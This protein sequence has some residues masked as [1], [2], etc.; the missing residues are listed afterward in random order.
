M[1]ITLVTFLWA[2]ICQAQEK[3]KVTLED[4]KLWHTIKTGATSDDGVWTSYSKTYMN[5]IDTLYLKNTKS[6]FEYVFPMGYNEKITKKGDRFAFLISGS[7][8]VLNTQSGKQQEYPNVIG[9]ELSENGKYLI[10]QSANTLTFEFV[11]SGKTK[12]LEHVKEYSVSPNQE[13]VAV[14]QNNEGGTAIKLVSLSDLTVREVSLESFELEYQQAVWNATGNTLGYYIFDKENKAYTIGCLKVDNLIREYKLDPIAI[15]DFPP[16]M[17]IIK[18]QLYV[19][20]KGDKVFF[21]TQQKDLASHENVKVWKSTDKELPPKSKINYKVW[22]VWLPLEDKVYEIEQDQ[23]KVCAITDNQEKAVLLDNE[24]YLPL[25]EYGDRYSDVYLMDLNTGQKEKIIEKQ[26]R[27]SWHLVTEP[28]GKYIAYFKDHHWWSYDIKNKTHLCI[29]KSIVTPFYKLN[30]DRLDTHRAF[31]FGG[32]T[33]TGELLVY[34]EY[35]VWMIAANGKKKERLTSGRSR[36]VTYRVHKYL[37][38]SIRDGFYGY[39]E[40]VYDLK[41]GLLIHTLNN[42]KLSEGFGVWNLKTG[43]TEITHNDF[44]IQYIKRISGNSFLYLSK[45]FDEPLQI[46]NVK[47]DGKQNIIVKSNEHQKQFYWGKSELIYYQS[48]EGKRLKGALFYPANYNDEVNYP[49]IVSIYENKSNALHD[50]VAPSLTSYTGINLTNFTQEGYFVLYPDIAYELN[51]PGK[52]ALDCVNAAIDKALEIGSIDENKLGLMGHSF[53]GFEASYIVSQTNRFKAAI[54]SAGVNDLLSFYLDIDSSG[55]SN[56]ERFENEQFRN[57]IPFTELAFQKESPIMN[58]QTINTPLLI[59]TGLEDKL[60]PPSYSIKLYTALW[61]L[62]KESTL[63]LYSNEQHVLVNPENQK[64]I[65]RKTLSWFN[66]HLKEV[67]PSE[68]WINEN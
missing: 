48:P 1:K 4:Y 20:D 12:Q 32:W 14:I 27:A 38:G 18:S 50:Y 34:D 15:P 33:T 47:T 68:E 23:L 36:E 2:G 39:V 55:L 42:E 5:H 7:L 31:G 19:S 11:K 29:T 54:A 61:R 51:S 60:V 21:D 62:K 44:K 13:Y 41:E 9:Y 16:G 17:H 59:W 35:D 49:M 26:L 37:K 58:V 63:L 24:M 46:V 64:D 30:S 40:D 56:M 6:D 65:T 43:F 10:Y 53:G 66:Y 28:N 57:Q 67:V 3:R 52:S 8:Y 45:R 25:Y 22:N